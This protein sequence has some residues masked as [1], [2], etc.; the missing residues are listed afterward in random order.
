MDGFTGRVVDSDYSTAKN[1]E[2]LD[3]HAKRIKA[4][5]DRPQS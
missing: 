3:D 5:E 4:L 2:R 1:R